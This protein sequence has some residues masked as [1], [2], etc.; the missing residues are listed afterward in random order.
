MP[1]HRMDL[2]IGDAHG[3]YSD[4]SNRIT[5]GDEA[6]G[7][8]SRGRPAVESAEESRRMSVDPVSVLLWIVA[9][10]M[11]WGAVAAALVLTLA[12]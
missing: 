5:C 4:F 6:K 1:R 3:V 10:L 7:V 2:T 12:G 8:R 11:F 9:P